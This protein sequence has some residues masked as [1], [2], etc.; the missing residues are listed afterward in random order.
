MQ[1]C[2]KVVE[3]DP[4]S[5]VGGGN[6]ACQTLVWLVTDWTCRMTGS[7]ALPCVKAVVWLRMGGIICWVPV[8]VLC[9]CWPLKLILTSPC[10]FLLCHIGAVGIASMALEAL[11]DA[12]V[13]MVCKPTDDLT[14][15]FVPVVAALPFVAD[16][17]F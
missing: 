16:F 17:F 14:A 3:C 6:D 1:P 5:D 15:A 12:G 2:V 4:C 11:V 8:D 10:H 13:T 9:V 7:L